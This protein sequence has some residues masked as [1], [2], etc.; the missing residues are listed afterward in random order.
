VKLVGR[1]NPYA[2]VRALFNAIGKHENLDEKARKRGKR[3]S[4]IEWAS[5]QKL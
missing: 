4:S 5:K 1:R 3:F 2:M